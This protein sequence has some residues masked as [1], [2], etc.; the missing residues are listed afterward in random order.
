VSGFAE[1]KRATCQVLKEDG[2]SHQGTAFAALPDGILLTCHHV[3]FGLSKI[4]IRLTG[5]PTIFEAEY[6]A[7]ISDPVSDIAVLRILISTPAVQLGQIRDGVS[8]YAYGFRPRTIALEPE[9]HTH[10]G[11]LSPG[12]ILQFPVSDTIRKSISTRTKAERE[13]WNIVPEKIRAGEARNLTGAIGLVQGLSGGPVYDPLLR[14]VVGIIRA[15]EG[16]ESAYVI[17][18][19][20]VFSAWPKL[21]RLNLEQVGDE[22]ID[23]LRRDYEIWPLAEGAPPI[24]SLGLRYFSEL[25]KSHR[26]FGGRHEELE[27]L[28]GHLDCP[29]ARYFFITGPPGFGKTA[30]LA[31]WVQR[32]FADKIHVVAHFLSRSV[33]DSIEAE[34]CLG[35]L[36]EQLLSF[37]SL[38]GE[39]PQQAKRLKLLYSDLLRLDP[40][41]DKTL[42]V[43]IDG[44]DE[45]LGSWEP[46]PS[47][48]PFNLPENVHVVFSARA[49]ADRDWL[50]SLD[51]DLPNSQTISLDRLDKKSIA[52]ILQTVQIPNLR[53]ELIDGVAEN[54][55]L[56]SNGDPFY[57]RDILRE[58]EHG[59]LGEASL[60]HF[61]ADHGQ[62]LK[63]WWHQA[64]IEDDAFVDLMGLLAA[65]RGWLKSNQ[66][67]SISK[68]DKLRSLNI[69]RV[70]QRAVRYIIGNK[71]DG[72]QFSDNRIQRFV[73]AQIG[74][75]MDI[76]RRRFADFCLRWTEKDMSED[77]KDYIFTY[78]AQHLNDIGRYDLLLNLLS[79]DWMAAKWHRDGSYAGLIRDFDVAA[80][81]ALKRHPPDYPI[82]VA[83]GMSRGTART[84]S[85]ELPDPALTAMVKL[86]QGDELIQM[87][88]A[89]K[90][91]TSER[92]DPTRGFGAIG[93]MLKRSGSQMI[94]ESRESIVTFVFERLSVLLR[95]GRE[96]WSEGEQ[97][98]VLRKVI[99]VLHHDL[100]I[101]SDERVGFLS[102][103]QRH[104]STRLFEPAPRCAALCLVAQAARDTPEERGLRESAHKAAAALLEE[105]P[106]LGDYIAA[107]SYY[108]PLLPSAQGRWD[109]F[110]STFDLLLQ[111]GAT[112]TS[113]VDTSSELMPEPLLE[114]LSV[115]SFHEVGDK[116]AVKM[117][118]VG[119][120]NQLLELE[121]PSVNLLDSIVRQLLTIGEIAAAIEFLERLC[122]RSPEQGGALVYKGLPALAEADRQLANSLFARAE[123]YLTQGAVARAKVWL[124]DWTGV[125]DALNTVEPNNLADAL[126]GVISALGERSNRSVPHLLLSA[127][128]EL[129][130]GTPVE[131]RALAFSLLAE[132]TADTDVEIATRCLRKAIGLHL[133]QLP[134]VDTDSLFHFLAIALHQGKRYTKVS[135]IVNQIASPEVRIDVL[136]G[137]I[138]QGLKEGL[139]ETAIYDQTLQR[140]LSEIGTSL[141]FK[142][143]SRV[144][145]TLTELQERSPER[146]TRMH[147]VVVEYSH[148]LLDLLVNVCQVLQVNKSLVEKFGMSNFER[149][150]LTAGKLIA[151]VPE[152]AREVVRMIREVGGP[153]EIDRIPFEVLYARAMVVHNPDDVVHVAEHILEFLTQSAPLLHSTGIS[154]IVGICGQLFAD[155]SGSKPEDSSR[156]LRKLLDIVLS[157]D[158]QAVFPMAIERYWRSLASVSRSVVL[159]NRALWQMPLE[160]S[161][162]RLVDLRG[163]PALRSAGY[164]LLRL[165]EPEEA[166]R[167][168]LAIPGEV[169]RHLAEGEILGSANKLSDLGPMTPLEELYI[170]RGSELPLVIVS[171]IRKIGHAREQLSLWERTLAND[172]LLASRITL[173]EAGVWSSLLPAVMVY[174]TEVIEE[175]VARLKEFDQRFA[176]AGQLIS[177]QQL[178]K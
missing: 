151:I 26:V 74:E 18:L 28:M 103:L 59:Y 138:E 9:G 75:D 123:P 6:L 137:L 20:T 84:L 144:I 143:L 118:L 135:E 112:Q 40:Q 131:M 110:R 48:F 152:K 57:I 36:C 116:G 14:R 41:P 111:G 4:Q 154:T 173:F 21:H 53:S 115:A 162:N 99:G 176:A 134:A 67:V 33:P 92:L 52:E 133:I 107:Q 85:L 22:P 90:G 165:G 128:A 56:I 106:R 35:N 105:I 125:K 161:L 94:S 8:V 68:E 139:P 156:L 51:L 146:T 39:L 81:A 89:E 86:G 5:N 72:Y 167:A 10:S 23:A 30:L 113:F 31:T 88:R 175:A 24:R 47:M 13:S 19:D 32:K 2:L 76:Y 153:D 150:A 178:L 127:L 16:S 44:L 158:S 119:F 163:V 98:R 60:A 82:I 164:A 140:F 49:I 63:Q 166:R 117:L 104:I 136:C 174:G 121:Q 108:L 29:A 3:I 114:L 45:A 101:T 95:L 66:I 160:S 34:H 145:N 147:Q 149:L 169:E 17:P 27:K 58:L 155:L 102:D 96:F 83:L 122:N 62:Y 42:L 78:A 54:L 25:L 93:E 141:S 15:V 38:G 37:H 157:I 109:A 172:L 50:R 100:G 91:I 177:E 11:D 1:V 170:S 130:E 132:C 124:Q 168:I 61:P 69:H 97:V 70:L 12:Q 80:E 46:D 77:S 142:G 71:K 55:D 65:A 129:V 43:V 126:S 79:P 64:D 73:E 7:D 87:L 171:E 159:Q 148:N 120:G